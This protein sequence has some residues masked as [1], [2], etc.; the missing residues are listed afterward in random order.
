MLQ[1][2]H[3]GSYPAFINIKVV[4]KESCKK[5]GNKLKI[6]FLFLFV[7]LLTLLC[8]CIPAVVDLPWSIS[9]TCIPPELKK[10]RWSKPLGNAAVH[11]RL[12]AGSLFLIL[13]LFPSV[14]CFSRAP[15]AHGATVRAR[16]LL[17][18]CIWVPFPWGQELWNVPDC[19]P[20]SSGSPLGAPS[21]HPEQASL[22]AWTCPTQ[23]LWVGPGKAAP[24]ASL[25][26]RDLPPCTGNGRFSLRN[27]F[28]H[29]P[30]AL[31]LTPQWKWNWWFS[32]FP[33]LRRDTFMAQSFFRYQPS[34]H[35]ECM[36]LPS[37]DRVNW[38][39]N[40]RASSA[41]PNKFIF[42][43]FG[44]RNTWKPMEMSCTA[45]TTLTAHLHPFTWNPSQLFNILWAT[46]Y[47]MDFLGPGLQSNLEAVCLHRHD[48]KPGPSELQFISVT[49]SSARHPQLMPTFLLAHLYHPSSS[50]LWPGTS[51][52]PLS[53]LP[54]L[55]STHTTHPSS[56]PKDTLLLASDCG[57]FASVKEKTRH[58]LSFVCCKKRYQRTAVTHNLPAK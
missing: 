19:R 47:S 11:Y 5:R 12:L 22:G 16:L 33:S 13:L 31:C 43:F 7:L 17:S 25:S 51:W 15:K 6:H 26:L 53:C 18:C 38:R 24:S 1:H 20:C 45:P 10:R 30:P 55:L 56:L 39:R 41:L 3:H 42:Y 8:I 52:T 23:A 50:Q 29:P 58:K 14:S 2:C 35:S 57:V 34:E 36:A 40:T 27:T 49:S 21:T 4:L 48:L 44:A 37:W 32:C 28:F 9:I 54:P 46:K